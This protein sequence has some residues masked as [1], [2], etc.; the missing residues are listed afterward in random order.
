M[1]IITKHD[2]TSIMYLTV[3]MY[4]NNIYV[5]GTE[6]RGW[7]NVLGHIFMKNIVVIARKQTDKK[8]NKLT[9]KQTNQKK[10]KMVREK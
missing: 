2:T 9:N 3:N 1:E 10:K 7:G 6:W 8:K 5:T 4:E